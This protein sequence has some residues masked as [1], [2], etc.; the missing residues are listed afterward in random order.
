M[1]PYYVCDFCGQGFHSLQEVT[2]HL[3]KQHNVDD[4]V[5]VGSIDQSQPGKLI[6]QH[7]GEE[8]ITIDLDEWLKGFSLNDT[9]P[10]SKV[11]TYTE[12]IKNVNADVLHCPQCRKAYQQADTPFLL[13]DIQ[14]GGDG[15]LVAVPIRGKCGH[16]WQV[17]FGLHRGNTY[18]FVRYPQANP[19]RKKPTMPQPTME[20]L[21]QW[22]DEG[23]CYTIAGCCWVETDGTCEHGQPSWLLYLGMI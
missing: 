14:W 20:E 17:C 7:T 9:T 11:I 5:Q 4:P 2:N 15:N 19:G 18:A 16:N 6:L 3:N 1:K 12:E 21:S 13:E 8:A 23:G 22:A 10:I